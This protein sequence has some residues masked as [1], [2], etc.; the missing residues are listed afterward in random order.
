M[1]TTKHSIDREGIL[2]TRLCTHKEDVD[3]INQMQLDQLTGEAEVSRPEAILRCL[4][5]L[6]R[7]KKKNLSV[8]DFLSTLPNYM[9]LKSFIRGF[10]NFRKNSTK[11]Y[12]F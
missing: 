3:Q 5:L 8:S 7:P 2:A 4:V 6:L 1:D 11:T 10:R 12:G 9:L